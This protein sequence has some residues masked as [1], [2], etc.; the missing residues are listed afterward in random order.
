MLY[1]QFHNN[2]NYFISTLIHHH[3]LSILLSSIS[4]SVSL[5]CDHWALPSR[6]RGGV[7]N[8]GE[9]T[10]MLPSVRSTFNIFIAGIGPDPVPDSTDLTHV[11]TLNV[12]MTFLA[13]SF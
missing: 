3:L 7:M 2:I 8:S 1:F 5:L 12:R 11:M 4:H 10:P 6:G 9:C 13:F